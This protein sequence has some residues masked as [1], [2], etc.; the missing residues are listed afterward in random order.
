MRV[1]RGNGV[2]RVRLLK[3]CCPRPSAEVLLP[4]R[5]TRTSR[6][7]TCGTVTTD[8]TSCVRISGRGTDVTKNARV[9]RVVSCPRHVRFRTARRGVRLQGRAGYSSSGGAGGAPPSRTRS[10]DASGSGSAMASAAAPHHRASVHMVRPR[11]PGRSTAPTNEGVAL[12][13][14]ITITSAAAT[15][16][17]IESGRVAHSRSHTA[18][19]ESVTHATRGPARGGRRES[20]TAN[21]QTR[22]VTPRPP[23]PRGRAAGP[24]GSAPSARLWARCARGRRRGA[25]W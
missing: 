13:L 17:E 1:L 7:D 8:V 2:L 18:V 10:R 4:R 15:A 11:T 16:P 12:F 25:R 3:S 9:S 24:R 19:H 23:R 21:T 22:S 20:N 5:V 14:T 6:V